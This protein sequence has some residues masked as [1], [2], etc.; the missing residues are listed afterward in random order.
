MTKFALSNLPPVPLPEP[1]GIKNN[2]T[3]QGITVTPA[4]DNGIETWKIIIII[5]IPVGVCFL[6][7]IAY[8]FYKK[9]K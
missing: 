6:L 2:D 9:S 5:V 1:T 3:S 7:G 8:L 4:P